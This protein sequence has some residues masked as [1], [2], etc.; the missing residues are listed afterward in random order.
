MIFQEAAHHA[1]GQHFHF[2]DLNPPTGHAAMLRFD[3]NGYTARF[4]M[5]PNAL[6]HFGGKAFLHLKPVR[7]AVQNTRQL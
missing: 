1:A 7:K 3:H 4:K 6:C 5:V 2:V